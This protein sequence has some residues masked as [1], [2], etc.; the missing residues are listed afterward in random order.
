MTKKCEFI[1]K[2]FP[3]SLGRGVSAFTLA[4]VLITLGVIG[5]IAAIT[6]PTLINNFQV[7]SW[8]NGLK[9][10]YSSL[11]N[12]FRNMALEYDMDL[13]N[14]GIFDDIDDATFSDRID[15]AVRKH[16]K[17]VKSCK[18][19]DKNCAYDIS[20]LKNTRPIGEKYFGPGYY[21]AYLSDSSIIS[22][23]NFGCAESEFIND[24]NIKYFCFII[25]VD[26]NGKKMPNTKGKDI[27]QFDVDEKGVLWSA[28]SLEYAKSVY[29]ADNALN[30]VEYWKNNPLQCGTPG[31]KLKDD[32]ADKIYGQNCVARIMENNWKMDYLK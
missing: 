30:G 1:C 19:G 21:V 20:E 11:S 31:V 22:F 32:T 7:S 3:R 28:T 12:G 9:R 13:R 8:E 2:I 27:F 10:T 5:V 6:I 16:F 25:R 29:G 14:S 24:S 17:V 23:Q 15:K 18:I 4:E 26:I